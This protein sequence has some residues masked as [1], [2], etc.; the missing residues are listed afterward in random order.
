MISTEVKE[1]RLKALYELREN[2]RAWNDHDT[3]LAA[4]RE[5]TTMTAELLVTAPVGGG[6]E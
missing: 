3:V 2:A 5:I 1:A 4:D 6:P